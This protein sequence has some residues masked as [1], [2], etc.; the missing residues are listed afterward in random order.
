MCSI[1]FARLVDATPLVKTPPTATPDG[2]LVVVV[3][4]TD[5]V[6]LAGGPE[7]LTPYILPPK[8]GLGALIDTAVAPET[9]DSPSKASAEKPAVAA[10]VVV[11]AP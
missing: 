7:P 8:E 9:P 11:G 10:A 5:L 1:T 3:P 2:L 4:I 6:R